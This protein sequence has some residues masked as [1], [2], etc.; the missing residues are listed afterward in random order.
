MV[1]VGISMVCFILGMEQYTIYG[2]NVW[3]PF[4]V[5]NV[6]GMDIPFLSLD[7]T[8]NFSSI[9]FRKVFNDLAPNNIELIM[10]KPYDALLANLKISIFLGIVIGM[11]SIIYQ[12][13][14]FIGPGLYKKE[15]TMV[16]KIIGPTTL[17]F[18]AGCAF[19]YFIITPFTINF[20]YGYGESMG[21]RTFVSI[22]EFITFVLIFICAFGI[23]FELPVVMGALTSVGIVQPAF[24]KENWRIA[25]FI[26][27]VIAAIITPDASGITQVMV[28]GPMLLLY[29]V[30]YY[31]SKYIHNR[32][33]K[34]ERE[35]D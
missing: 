4:H 34:R 6:F 12:V 18:L 3:L 1:V 26:M 11:P 17:L 20:L 24:W 14:K 5:Y 2:Y 21:A 8:N 10:I 22:S 27:V 31:V 30:G 23:I 19:S 33:L 25:L 16:L 29:I 9:F 13:G 32:N 15:K 28:V 7:I 35:I